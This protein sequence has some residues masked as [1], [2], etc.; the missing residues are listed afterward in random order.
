MVLFITVLMSLVRFF[1]VTASPPGFYIDEA[2]ISAQVICL[3]QSGHTLQGVQ[4]PLFSEVLGGGYMTP[5]YLAPALAWTSAFG[6]SIAS[7]RTLPAFFSL[8]FIMGSYLLGARVWQSRESGLYCALAA[9]LSPWVFQFSRIAWDP[10]LA[11]AYLVWAF[12][13]LFSRTRFRNYEAVAGGSLLACA[14]YCYPSLRVQIAIT[15][16]VVA[17]GWLKLKKLSAQQAGLAAV[18]CF[19]VSAPLLTKTLSGEIQGRFAML[20]VFNRAGSFSGGLVMML[21]NFASFFSPSYLLLHGDSNLRH[22]TSYFGILSYLDAF[23]ILLVVI[24]FVRRKPITAK[25]EIV[26]VVI[27]F[28][29]GLLPAALTWESNPHALRSFGA[30]VFLCLGVGHVLAMSAR[31][32]RFVKVLIPVVAIAWSALF[33]TKYFESYPMIAGPWFD[34][35][36]VA[37]ARDLKSVH[38]LSEIDARLK[39]AGVDYD[40][41]ATAY[42]RLEGGEMTCSR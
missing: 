7:F 10:S 42:Y 5:T 37:F 6:D 2:A 27:G 16:L 4:W 1:N 33:V 40:P 29:A 18:T 17:Y 21:E 38:R 32:F 15:L 23:A 11:P 30:V 13:F 39:A 20:S 19:A 24:W 35:Q 31:E 41:R 14:A 9:A 3:K 26:F 8:L 34:D 25:F 36:V 22:S 28:L 12:A